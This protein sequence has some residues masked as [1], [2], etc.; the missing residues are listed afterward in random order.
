[1]WVRRDWDD[2]FNRIRKRGTAVQP[3]RPVDRSARNRLI[4]AEGYSLAELDDAGL[5][6]E[7]AEVLGLPVD[8]LRVGSDQAN[9]TALQMFLRASRTRY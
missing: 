4:P 8:A 6:L 9:V 5:S 2:F 7:Q 1:M 3:P